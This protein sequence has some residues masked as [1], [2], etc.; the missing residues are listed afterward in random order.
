MT[1]TFQMA[2]R[3]LLLPSALA[4]VVVAAPAAARNT[5]GS[6]GAS[7]GLQ[8]SIEPRA[9][10]PNE[11]VTLLLCVH[12]D[13]Q[14]ST[15]RVQ[16]GDSFTF[17]FGDGTVGACG[18]VTAFSPTGSLEDD[19][20]TCAT[21]SSEVTLTYTGAGAEWPIGEAACAT[22]AYG[23]GTRPSTV[24]TSQRVGNAGAFAPPTPAAIVLA[25]G[26][27]IGTVGPQ[28]PVGPDGPMGLTGLTG[29]PGPVGPVGATGPQG[30]EGP[31]GPEGPSNG[32]IGARESRTS[33]GLFWGS[34]DEGPNPLLI[35]GLEA[36]L[37]TQAQSRLLIVADM[38]STTS[39]CPHV[40]SVLGEILVELDGEIVARRLMSAVTG[41]EQ[42]IVTWLSP[43]LEAGDHEVRVL[44][45]A[46]TA[47][48]PSAGTRCIGS[49]DDDKRLESRMLAIEVLP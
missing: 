21:T 34:W 7:I 2:A 25:V 36:L 48:G 6:T 20:F 9:M 28:G 24:S 41:R 13:G 17:T 39:E 42:H 22:M 32:A 23:P 16:T 18:D 3:I 1:T 37:D 15:R 4:F 29:E 46:T 45:A 40:P 12:S 30:P 27:D 35:P 44:L 49:L 8:F 19:D 38:V 26:A 33:I 47:A 14:R 31:M 10:R 43:P 11:A 5:G